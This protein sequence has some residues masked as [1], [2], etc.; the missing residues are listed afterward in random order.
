MQTQISGAM[1]GNNEDDDGDDDDGHT[2]K[3]TRKEIKVQLILIPFGR[4]DALLTN[5]SSMR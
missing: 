4:A 1:N 3:K 5:N 2:H